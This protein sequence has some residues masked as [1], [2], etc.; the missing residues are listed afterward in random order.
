MNTYICGT[1]E[2]ICVCSVTSVLSDSCDPMNYSL[3]G[4]SLHGILQAWLLE[5]FAMPSFRGSS[6][7]K[8]NY[9]SIKIEKRE[10]DQKAESTEHLVLICQYDISMAG[11]LLLLKTMAKEILMYLSLQSI[12]NFHI[13]IFFQYVCS[14]PLNSLFLQ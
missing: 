11:L 7:P 12:S 3:P 2:M 14:H 5:W 10:R 6:W 9:T 4:S 8:A 1:F 13:F